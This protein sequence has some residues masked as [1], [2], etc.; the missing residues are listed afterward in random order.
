M[1]ICFEKLSLS[2]YRLYARQYWIIYW[3]FCHG[4]SHHFSNCIFCFDQSRKVSGIG[5]YCGV[6]DRIDFVWNYFFGS[7]SG[8]V[9]GIFLKN[10]ISFLFFQKF[11][12]IKYFFSIFCIIRFEDFGMTIREN[13]N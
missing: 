13:W 4:F 11:R 6:L 10:I 7:F 2:L 8:N 3:N 12:L 1:S 9:P 5:H